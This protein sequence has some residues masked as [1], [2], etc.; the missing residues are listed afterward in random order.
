M[1]LKTEFDQTM[2]QWLWNLVLPLSHF[3]YSKGTP[4]CQIKGHCCVSISSSGYRANY[5]LPIDSSCLH[6]A[7]SEILPEF[8]LS[9]A[10]KNADSTNKTLGI[11][12][13]AKRRFLSFTHN[14]CRCR[15]VPSSVGLVLNDRTQRKGNMIG[16]ICPEAG[17][18]VHTGI[19]NHWP[20]HHVVGR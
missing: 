9:D 17:G 16:T 10:W 1:P 15:Y 6:K 5:P 7:I 13:V 12:H 4:S 3:I 18:T 19:F 11:I 2:V 14:G 8:E 20:Q